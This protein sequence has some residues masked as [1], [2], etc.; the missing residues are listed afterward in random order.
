LRISTRTR[1]ETRRREC[2][3][4]SARH[5]AGRRLPASESERRVEGGRRPD[6]W[7]DRDLALPLQRTN[8]AIRTN[9]FDRRP[10]CR[11]MDG[12]KRNRLV[13][14]RLAS[15]GESGARKLRD[16]VACGL[17]IAVAARVA[18]LQLVVREDANVG[19]PALRRCARLGRGDAAEAANRE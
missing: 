14:A 4:D 16:D 10:F 1:R 2:R 12:M 8:L 7:D 3:E 15:G 13:V 11:E 17:A 19:P 9:E 5:Q 18:S 6:A